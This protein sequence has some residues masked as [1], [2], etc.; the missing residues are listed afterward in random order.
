MAIGCSLQSGLCPIA[1]DS[2][3]AYR[4]NLLGSGGD[5]LQPPA[6]PLPYCTRLKR[7]LQAELT[8]FRWRM[9][10]CSLQPGLFP[11]AQDWR[12]A[13][14]LNLLGSGGGWLAAASSLASAPS[15]KIKELFIE[16]TRF[17]WRRIGCSL[18]S[19]LCLLAHRAEVAVEGTRQ[20]PICLLDIHRT[21]SKKY[22]SSIEASVR[23]WLPVHSTNFLGLWSNIPAPRQYLFLWK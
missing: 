20:V 19:G 16:L 12:D 1:Q 18:Q 13:Y 6:W 17:R 15:H 8:G 10:G 22:K 4:L 11:I 14:R 9:I 3:A 21:L 7:C 5:W 2:R 23:V